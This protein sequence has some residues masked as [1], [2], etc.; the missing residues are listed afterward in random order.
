[1][2]SVSATEALDRLAFLG[3]S[4]RLEGDKLKVRGPNRPEVQQAVSELRRDRDAAVAWL[5]EK[6]SKAPTSEEVRAMLPPGV[7]LVSYRPK[8]APFAVAPI[9][10]VTNAGKFFRTYL[11]DLRWRVEHSESHAVP[12]LHDIMAKLAEGGVELE[13]DASRNA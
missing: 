5:K 13:I 3:C 2:G 8:Q 9:S 4:V 10:I 12:P 7:R 6:E 1:M 11:R